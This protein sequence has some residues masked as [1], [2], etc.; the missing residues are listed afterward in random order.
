MDKLAQFAARGF[1]IKEN[2]FIY[3]T[4]DMDKT[5]K[6][7][8][9]T[10]GWYGRVI[11]RD[12]SGQ[13]TYGFLTDVPEEITQSFVVDF[14]GIHLWPGEPSTQTLALIQISDVSALREHVLRQGWTQVSDIHATGA[15][16]KTCELTT[17]DGSRLWFF[18]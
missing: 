13:G 9:D 8:Q 7:F 2:V 6:W 1:Y 18:E 10:L 17:V 14:K 12:A 4:Q 5:L 3:Y 11:D 16:G 15:S